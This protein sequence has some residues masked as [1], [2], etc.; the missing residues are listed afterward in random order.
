MLKKTVALI[1][2][3]ILL[4]AFASCAAPKV[5]VHP[6]P[7][8]TEAAVIP[9][10][11]EE[12][13]EVQPEAPEEIVFTDDCGREVTIPAEINS[14]VPSGALS[15][16]I[17]FAVA[18]EKLVA[19]STD[20]KDYSKGIIAEEYYSLPVLGQIYGSADLNVE[21]L[22]ATNPQLII[23]IGEAKKTIV[24]DMD[25]LQTQTQIPSIHI[26][27]NL[28]NMPEVFLKLGELLGK[29]EKAKEL[30]DFCK[31]VYDRTGEIMGKV[32]ENKMKGLYVMGE[33]GL[34][35]LAK[36][37][38]H[39]EIL[40]MLMENVAEIDNPSSKGS[41]NEV[42]MEQIALWD[43]EF[44]VFSS[45]SIYDSVSEEKS[46]K[47]INAVKHEYYVET[48]DNPYSWLGMPPSVQRYCGLIWLTY[49]LY[50]EYCEYDVKA[51]ITEYYKLFYG[52]ELSDEQYSELTK[53]AFL[54]E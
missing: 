16:I 28:E 52:C 17:L 44:I 30:S 38:Y 21:E 26:E 7:E 42:T 3:A 14:I 12:E 10:K 20:F 22:A 27:A 5:E 25:A 53:N 23:D 8:K 29:T 18:P 15:Q 36:G 48:P 6:E 2:A 43:P 41:G 45:D 33:D 4:F 11:V 37:S 54:T 1:I 24:E 31:R 46:W 50:P 13:P 34:N 32:G 35:V 9:E 19:L 51:E 40:D 39:A 47:N 49:V